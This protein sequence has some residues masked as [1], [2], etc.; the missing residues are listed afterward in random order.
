[1]RPRHGNEEFESKGS[2]NQM[3][4]MQEGNIGYVGVIG[5]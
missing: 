5:K 3:S 4:I 1:M 2:L